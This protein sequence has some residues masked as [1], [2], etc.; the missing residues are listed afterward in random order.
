M[1]RFKACPMRATSP[2]LLCASGD[3]YN[4]STEPAKGFNC[5]GSHCTSCASLQASVLD[6]LLD[7]VCEVDMHILRCSH[8]A[9]LLINLPMAL[10]AGSQPRKLI[11]GS[12]LNASNFGARVVTSE[13]MGL[14]SE[15]WAH[16]PL[17]PWSCRSTGPSGP[18][19]GRLWA[20]GASCR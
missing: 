6:L 20:A 17:L 13:A 15:F 8:P 18:W 11:T 10:S 7:L 14:W 19:L 16:C 3:A 5:V 4:P 12:S 2:C 1:A 9:I